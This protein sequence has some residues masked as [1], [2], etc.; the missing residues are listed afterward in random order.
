MKTMDSLI[1]DFTD[2]KYRLSS[3]DYVFGISINWS[4]LIGISEFIETIR[5][6]GKPSNEK[7]QS[8]S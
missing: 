7:E 1:S 5:Q 6:L 3:I 2:Y 8:L 4:T